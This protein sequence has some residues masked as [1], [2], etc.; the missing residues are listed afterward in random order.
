MLTYIYILKYLRKK[1]LNMA[2]SKGA[3][4]KMQLPPSKAIFSRSRTAKNLKFVLF[5]SF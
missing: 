1:M 5:V 4:K 2:D 3:W